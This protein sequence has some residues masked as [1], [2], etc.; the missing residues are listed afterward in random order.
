MPNPSSTSKLRIT[1]ALV[2]MQVFLLISMLFAPIPVAA[3]DP[4]A[5]PGQPDTCR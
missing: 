3:A 4:S 5:D 2:I 1:R